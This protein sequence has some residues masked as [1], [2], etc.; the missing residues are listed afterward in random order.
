ME[1]TLIAENSTGTLMNRKGEWGQN[2]PPKF[3]IVG[4]DDP[5]YGLQKKRDREDQEKEKVP[6]D[7]ARKSRKRR[8]LAKENHSSEERQKTSSSEDI[9]SPDIVIA[10]PDTQTKRSSILNFLKPIRGRS[11]LEN[12]GENQVKTQISMPITQKQIKNKN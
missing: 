6:K 5:D 11:E 3:G 12:S 10:G 8:K 4:V 9:Q 1:G 2:L 7:S